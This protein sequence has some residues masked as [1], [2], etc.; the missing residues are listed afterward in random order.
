[1][2]QISLNYA[3]RQWQRECHLAL[4]RFSVLALHR[5]AGKT[6]MALMQLIHK[7]MK[8]NL[9]L[10][11]FVY[12]APFLK[13]A[14]AVAWAR[15]KQRIEPLRIAG[16]VEINEGELSVLFR[17]N[18]AMIRIFGADNPDALRGLRVDGAVVDEV[19]QVKPEAWEDIIQPALSDRKGWAVFIGT[20]S[21]I[22][23]FSQLFYKAQGE[24]GD[25]HAARYTVYDTDALDPNEVARLKRDMNETSFDREYLCDFS[26][27]G[28]NQLISLSDAETASRM[29]YQTSDIEHAPKILG[30]DPAR[31]GDDRSVIMPRQGLVTMPPMVFRGMDNMTLAGMIA[32]KIDDWQPDA[33]FID[34]GAGGG[35]IDRLRQIGH[36]V[37]EIDFGGKAPDN[38]YVN[39]RAYMWHQ[40]KDWL[41][42]GGCIPNIN[43]LKLE[44]ATPTYS[45]D[46]MNRI[47]LESK[48]E[49]KKRLQ[50][51]ASPDLADALALTFA[52]P[53]QPSLRHIHPSLD[54]RGMVHDYDPF[55]AA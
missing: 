26:A 42:A 9:D 53:V 18:G 41:K 44:L 8:F 39:M 52:F 43:D 7:A 54:T 35:V 30:V 37:I 5:R 16:M 25:W 36:T 1:M 49:I 23:L 11:M 13:Q 15:L 31:F 20:P 12:I 14:K 46:A 27:A 4:K 10:G 3:P 19:A 38:R 24:G 50:G 40:M 45:F 51:G 55:A 29:V 21:G 32:K 28:D 6:E 48:D 47:K 17:H 33:V 34:A 22:N 2:K